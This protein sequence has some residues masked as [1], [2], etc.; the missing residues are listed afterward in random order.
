MFLPQKKTFV[1]WTF[2][3]FTINCT[4]ALSNN[5]F[6]VKFNYEIGSRFKVHAKRVKFWFRE[7]APAAKIWPCTIIPIRVNAL[8]YTQEGNEPALTSQL[9][10]ARSISRGMF[11]CFSFLHLGHVRLARRSTLTTALCVRNAFVR[12]VMS[13]GTMETVIQ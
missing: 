13:N 6:I 10:E 7:D 9:H 3:T 2:C 5:R 11:V 1:D 12:K 8:N 4:K